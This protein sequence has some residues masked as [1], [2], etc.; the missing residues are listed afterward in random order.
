[1]FCSNCGKKIEEGTKFCSGCGTPVIEAQTIPR[2]TP[3]QQQTAETKLPPVFCTNCGK[4]I[5]EGT[6]FCSGCGTPVVEQQAIPKQTPVQPQYQQQ[7][8]QYQQTAKTEKNP[9]QYFAGVFQKY[10]EFNGRARRSEFWWFTLFS[11]LLTLPTSWIPVLNIIVSLGFLLPGIAVGVR[12]M[13]DVG[14]S[15]GFLLIPV[16]NIILAATAG[17]AGHNQYGPD[18]K[19]E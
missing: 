14:K 17:D 12:R 13:H 19:N 3:V 6:K 16:Y 2:Q 4:K 5:E 9:F 15:G 1:M 8:Q 10:V 7:Y 11:F 18:P